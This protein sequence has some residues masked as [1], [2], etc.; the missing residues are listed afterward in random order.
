LQLLHLRDRFSAQ[1][2]RKLLVF[3]LARFA[4]SVTLCLLLGKLACFGLLLLIV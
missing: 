2:F 3:G 1:A 4:F